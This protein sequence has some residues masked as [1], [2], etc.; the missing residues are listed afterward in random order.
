MRFSLVPKL[1]L[2]NECLRSSASRTANDSQTKTCVPK[3]ELGNVS[4]PAQ[5]TE[6]AVRRSP[7]PARNAFRRTPRCKCAHAKNFIKSWSPCRP[8]TCFTGISTTCPSP[9][10]LTNLTILT[11]GPQVNNRQT[12]SFLRFRP[13]RSQ[14]PFFAK[15]KERTHVVIPPQANWKSEMRAARRLVNLATYSPTPFFTGT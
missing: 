8:N 12:A 1:Q 2:G 6:P 9:R 15:R 14:F 10:K 7:D 3:P 11:D 4:N 5:S 13:T